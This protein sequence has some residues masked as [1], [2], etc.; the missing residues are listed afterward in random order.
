MEIGVHGLV[1]TGSFDESG[2]DR[3]IRS[4]REAGFD[5]LELPLFDPFGMDVGAAVASLGRSPLAVN[6]SL[7]LP[8]HGDI[9]SLDRA[10]VDEGERILGRCL[11]VLDAL[12]R[13]ED[14]T[15][16]LGGVIYSQLA[17]YPEPASPQ[18]RSN[19]QD[20]LGRIADRA[21]GYGI[22]L[23]LEVVNRY[24]TNQFNTGRDGLAF[25]REIG[26]DNVTVHLDTYHMH[27]EETD[28]WQ[29][30]LDVGP[31][32]G[33]V[34]IGESHRGYLGT[35][36]VDFGTLF[37]AL[38]RISYD[39]PIVFESFSSRVV[40]SELS[41]SLAI[42]RDLWTDGMDLARHASSFIRNSIHTARMAARH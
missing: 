19:A 18:S 3:A 31:R 20:V 15:P 42:W 13:G 10:V 22:G 1:W 17:K 14:R 30:V 5:L 39:G 26:R 23:S 4:T 37:A 2:M 25:L 36:T 11:E 33:Y 32:L 12:N 7:G 35:G 28:M 6:A 40:H 9:T 27:I 38:E 34:H 24:E 21:A 8:P 29:P 41:R 16:M